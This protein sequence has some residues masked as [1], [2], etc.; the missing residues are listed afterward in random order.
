MRRLVAHAP[1]AAL[2]ALALLVA[3]PAAAQRHVPKTSRADTLRGSFTTAGRAWWDV[4]FYDLH[5][6]HPA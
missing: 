5:V 4:T 6:E 1:L 3:S 2:S